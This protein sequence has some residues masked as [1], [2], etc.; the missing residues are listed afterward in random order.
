MQ[1]AVVA[2]ERISGEVRGAFQF[3]EIGQD[4]I[5]PQPAFPNW[6]QPS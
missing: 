1:W 6:R 5:P 4:I 3:A 2:V